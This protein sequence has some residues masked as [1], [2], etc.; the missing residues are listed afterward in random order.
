M[1]IITSW[2]KDIV[3]EFDKVMLF[4]VNIHSN[5]ASIQDAGCPD[6][7]PEWRI[8]VINITTLS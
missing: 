3:E 4:H 2:H 7:H 1:L 6:Q 8:D 5:T